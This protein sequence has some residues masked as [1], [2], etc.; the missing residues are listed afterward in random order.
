MAL[1]LPVS[2]LSCDLGSV[3]LPLV[4]GVPFALVHEVSNAALFFF[5]AFPLISAMSRL[6]ANGGKNG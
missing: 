1:E 5:G 2:S 4:A 6:L 3:V